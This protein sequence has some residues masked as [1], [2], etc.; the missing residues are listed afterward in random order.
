M[1]KRNVQNIQIGIDLGT[2]NSE[3]AINNNG[4]VELVKNVFGDEYT[5]SVFGIDK[6]KNKIVGKKA[7]ERLYKYATSE[8]LANNKAEIKRLMGTSE[9]VH[10]ARIDEDL[11]PEEISAEILKGLKEDVLRKYPNFETR[12]A[13]ITVPDYFSILQAEATK[14]A[15]NLAG[16]DYVVLLQE[17]IA[18]AMAYG[19]MNTKNENWIVYDLGGG[20]FDVALISSK[21]GAL[22]VLGHNGDNFL[23]GKDF[24]LKIVDKIFVPKISETFSV[25]DF[26]RGSKQHKTIFSRMRLAAEDSKIDLSQ[27]GKTSVVV[28]DIGED[29]EGREMSL[30]VDFTRKEFEQLIKP[31]VDQTIELT[32]ETI[33]ESGI[34]QSAIHKIILVGGPTQIPYIKDRLNQEFKITVDSS[35]DPLTVVA[36]GACVFAASQRIPKEFLNKEK[37]VETGVKT[38]TLYY[39]PLTS[40][41]EVTV[42][43]VVEELKDSDDEYYIQI[44]SEGGFY[45]GSKEKLKGGK[46]LHTIALEPRKTNLFW[47]FLF[48][49][50]GNPVQIDPD[51]FTITHG[52]SITGVPISHSIGVAVAKRDMSSGFALTEMFE[53]FFEKNSVLPLR[54]TKT[55]K[56]VKRLKKGDTE[57]ALPIKVF[58]GESENPDRNHLICD[59]KITG[60]NLPYDLPD[61]TEVEI[62]IEVNKSREV[63]VEAFI[64][65]IDLSLNA[66]AT[67]HA[68]D[69]DVEQMESDLNA[70][71][72]RIKTIEANCTAEEKA[73]LENT[74][75]SVNTSIGNAHIDQEEKRKAHKQLKDLKIKLDNIEKSKELPQLT[76]E[77]N[78][79]VADIQKVIDTLGDDKEKG[80]NNDQLKTLK[81]EGEKA[82]E[83]KDKYLLMRVN[84]Q[85]KELGARVAL[86]NPA[87]WVY[88]FE[89]LTTENHTFL[90]EKE[91]SYYISKGKRAIELG[92]VDELK[93]CVHSLM[94]L[95]PPE[96]QETIRGN[97]SGI[98]H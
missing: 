94:L 71:R 21:D 49:K 30:V 75:Q 84:E 88:Q 82:I 35:V 38:L 60:E 73:K 74:V 40:E 54:D 55:Y 29:D 43:G 92:D 46:F 57:N 16:F 12:A 36:R 34:K 66:R 1:I 48:D 77:F 4:N 9:K 15:G 62:K 95:L 89:R 69:I 50:D 31:L 41:E 13:I 45:S 93:R 5:P 6:A 90:S 83:S 39:D 37:K 19:F 14:R 85:I 70:Q 67:I 47:I 61:G 79:G 18:A 23:G 32:K 76:K 20:T 17:P 53:P 8:D 44:Q 65:T 52:L 42:S 11:S 3:I 81:E 24:D 87:M 98:T 26:N 80:I 51:S 58:E 63:T 25:K 56:T 22:S 33:R 97:L 91:A 2:T 78:E 27:Y 64:P 72:E 96:E 86:A 28:E 59:L 68:E 7:R 10:F